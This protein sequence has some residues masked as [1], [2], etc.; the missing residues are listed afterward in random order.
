MHI[1]NAVC[2]LDAVFSKKNFKWMEFNYHPHYLPQCTFCLLRKMTFSEK[3]KNPERLNEIK[4]WIFIQA[5]F[6]PI[7]ASYNGTWFTAMIKNLI[8]DLR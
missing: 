8:S 3:K 4:T 2:I 5:R 7:L 1:N 6:P